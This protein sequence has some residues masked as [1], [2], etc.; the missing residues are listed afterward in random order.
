MK[1]ILWYYRPS[2][3]REHREVH[4]QHVCP[5]QEEEGKLEKLQ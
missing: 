3:S 5:Q 4:T 1:G 2:L